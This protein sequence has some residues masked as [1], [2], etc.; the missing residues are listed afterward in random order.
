LWA[1]DPRSTKVPGWNGGFET[2]PGNWG[3][4]PPC[5][6][7]TDWIP[8]GAATSIV[9]NDKHS[10][11]Y[12]ARLGSPNPTAGDSK[13]QQTFKAPPGATRVAFWYQA[14]C[15]DV[16]CS[17]NCIYDW[18]TATLTDNSTSQTTTMVVPSCSNT[19]WVLSPT[20]NV[21]ADGRTYT[22]AIT[23]HDDNYWGPPAPDPI[24]TY[25]DDM[26]FTGAAPLGD[27]HIVANLAK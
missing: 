7:C 2:G 4:G 3:N 21:I 26:V 25:V 14:I 15:Q 19:G 9:S 22:I 6:G 10:G 27:V 13:I 18:F 23:N 12:S 16:L 1:S 20:A 5:A 11:M 17:G 8:S 24:Y